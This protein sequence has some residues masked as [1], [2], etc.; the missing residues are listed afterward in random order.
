MKKENQNLKVDLSNL[1]DFD[2]S[3][4]WGEKK[5]TK[6]WDKEQNYKVHKKQK[7]TRRPQIKENKS[8][9]EEIYKITITPDRTV[10]STLKDT[11]KMTGKSYSIEE[12]TSTITDKLERLGI[13]IEYFEDKDEN[14]FY[15][16]VF[17]KSI[18]SSKH[19]AVEHILK[20][21]LE[22]IIEI[23]KEVTEK[24]NGIYQTILQCSDTK[25]LLP[26]KS[27]HDFESVIKN[28]LFENRINKKFDDFVNGLVK[29]DDNE[30]VKEWSETPIIKTK[31]KK[32]NDTLD[33]QDI[34]NIDQLRMV[35]DNLKNKFIKKFKHVNLC[36]NNLSKL[37]KEITQITD[38][39]I[40][41]SKKWRKDLFFNV[42]INFKKSGFCVFKHGDKKYLYACYAKQ[43]SILKDQLS[44]TCTKIVVLIKNENKISKTQVLNQ[45]IK[46]DIDKKIIIREIKWLVKEGYIREFSNN[47]LCIS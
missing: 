29:I 1:E 34:K 6:N 28:F 3:S 44:N 47:E 40:K 43:K 10:L 12:I 17:D 20:N 35:I 16:T 38:D 25:S 33:I 7:F 11:I 46:K 30:K 14:N 13:K 45:L 21:G 19:K 36:G 2:F 5:T 27:F 24:P 8:N 41:T 4:N 37:E 22:E 39:V 18:F 42:L 9:K 32:K 31:K 26:P 15:E 23:K